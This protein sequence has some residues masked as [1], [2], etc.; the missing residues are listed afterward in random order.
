MIMHGRGQIAYYVLSGNT[1]SRLYEL[2]YGTFLHTFTS[3][4]TI[5]PILCYWPIAP[6]AESN[7]EHLAASSSSLLPDL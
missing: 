3:A 2:H 1:I 6:M 7:S 4:I 5:V